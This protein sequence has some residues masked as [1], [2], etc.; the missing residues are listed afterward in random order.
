MRQ[1]AFQSGCEFLCACSAVIHSVDY[2]I[3]EG[4]PSSRELRIFPAGLHEIVI[5]ILLSYR[6]GALS[7]LLVR[8]MQRYGKIHLRKIL[9]SKDGQTLSQKISE[10]ALEDEI[11]MSSLG[12][13]LSSD[14][15]QALSD[16]IMTVDES[17]HIAELQNKMNAV[18]VS[19]IDSSTNQVVKQF[20]SEEIQ[21]LKMRMRKAIGNMFNEAV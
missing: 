6:H 9:Q 18:V 21:N 2:G 14:V 8:R 17:T 13:E 7:E 4:D 19:V 16:G 15:D 12:E 10:W 5:S 3:F 1:P 20:P 11:E